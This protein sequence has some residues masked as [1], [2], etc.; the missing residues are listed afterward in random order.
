MSVQPAANPGDAGASVFDAVTATRF[1]EAALAN[2]GREYPNQPAHA[3]QSAADALPPRALHPVFYGSYDWHSAVHMHW[4]LARV[5]R[6]HPTL[7][8]CTR[9]AAAFDSHFTP[10]AIAAECAY[11]D[12]RGTGSFERTYGWAWLLKLADELSCIGGADGPRWAT[13][14]EPLAQ[15]FVARYLDYL[16]RADYP[17][18]HGMHA[19][20]AFGLLFA[21]AYARGRGDTG[22]VSVLQSKAGAWFGADRDLPA[23]WEP[24][25]AD[26]LSPALTEALLMR[27]ALDGP[28]FRHWFA[29]ALPGFATGQPAAI[30][31]PVAVR[32]R[33]DPQIVHLDGLNL[34][35]AWCFRGLARAVEDVPVAGAA[36]S[37]AAERHLQAGM[38][39]LASADYAGG[40]WLASFATLALTEYGMAA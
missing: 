2:I 15:R 7:S 36:A 5:R 22:F 30:F 14:L 11:L 39:G 40:H 25:G 20:S 1:A 18:R 4:L 8:V 31:Q 6:L 12:R 23:A 35:R 10:D 28:G 27:D 13:A 24:S 16:P 17:L 3:W 9:I 38:Q 34:A 33:G 26:F 29:A 19:N 21:L 37:A 32:D